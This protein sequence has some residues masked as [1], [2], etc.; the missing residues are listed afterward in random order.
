MLHLLT[1][2]ILVYFLPPACV[3]FQ[4]FSWILLKFTF[5]RGI[6]IHADIVICHL[7]NYFVFDS[8]FNEPHEVNI[9]K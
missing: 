4:R 7:T 8:I 9:D 6:E 3:I 5:S 2:A 1:P